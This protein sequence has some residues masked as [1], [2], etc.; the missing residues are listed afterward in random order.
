MQHTNEEKLWV[1]VEL[2]DDG[3]IETSIY[4]NEADANNYY[5]EMKARYDDPSK[6]RISES[7]LIRREEYIPSNDKPWG[8]LRVDIK[9][10]FVEGL[11]EDMV[12]LDQIRPGAAERFVCEKIDMVR[13]RTLDQLEDIIRLATQEQLKMCQDDWCGSMED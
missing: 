2:K 4:D 3:G 12:P 13:K 11:M 5:V 6:V 10:E 1:V 9:S 8:A 7:A